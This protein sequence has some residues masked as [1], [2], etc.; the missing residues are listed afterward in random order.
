MAGSVLLMLNKKV[1]DHV[2]SIIGP[3]LL[4]LYKEPPFFLVRAI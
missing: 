1:D 2:D 4:S 3:L